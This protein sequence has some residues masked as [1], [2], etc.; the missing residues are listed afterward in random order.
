MSW[1]TKIVGQFTPEIDRVTIATD[2]DALL[3]D[4]QV[5]ED[6]RAR[7]LDAITYADPVA[8]R[9]EYESKYRSHWDSGEATDKS[10]II[11]VDFDDY[12][13]LPYDLLHVGRHVSLSLADLFPWLSYRVMASLDRRYL[14]ALY[15][16]QEHYKSDNLGENESKD[17]VLRHAFGI[18]P[19]LIKTAPDLLIVLLRLHY[20]NISLPL[21]LQNRLTYLLNRNETF[22][23]WPL[24]KIISDRNAFFDFIQERW[25]IFLERTIRGRSDVLTD[26]ATLAEAEGSYNFQLAGPADIPFDHPEVRVYMDNLFSEGLLRQVEFSQYPSLTE[27]WITAGI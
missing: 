17:F 4:E 27:S 24:E 15:A 9:F 19:E 21:D 6:L 22:H 2:P 3:L 26:I 16:W 8:F 25:P 10:V 1:R 20:G 13:L 18:N 12:G 14:D 5:V 7:R 23:A 11:R